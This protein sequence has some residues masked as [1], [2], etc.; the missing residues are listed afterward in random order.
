MSSFLKKWIIGDLRPRRFILSLI[1]VPLLVYCAIFIGALLFSNAMIF[2]PGPPSYEL[3]YPFD[4]F[5]TVTEDTIAF[6][7][8][9]N[10]DAKYTILFSHGNAEDIGDISFITSTLHSHGFNTMTY[11]YPG[12]GLSSGTPNEKSVNKTI[13]AV[14]TYLVTEKN[15]PPNRIILLGRSVG[16]GPSTELAAKKTVGGLI[17][18]SSFT[19]AFRTFTGRKILPFDCF[20]NLKRLKDVKIPTLI[21]HGKKDD[22][23][24]FSHGKEL[25]V[26]A[27]EPKFSLWLDSAAHNDVMVLGNKDYFTEIQGYSQYLYLLEQKPKK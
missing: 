23:I 13:E 6:E 8:R 18:E 11:D 10:K 5:V 14:Y 12:Y 22:V 19:S 15:I 9:E 21:I 7:F 25:L 17:L 24:P 2:K 1:A 26:A 4:Q 20:D 16:G 27:N 3:S